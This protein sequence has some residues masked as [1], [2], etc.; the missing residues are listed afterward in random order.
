MGHI[1]KF[2]SEETDSEDEEGT[3]RLLDIGKII[4]AK[5][6]K[7][8]EQRMYE[9]I[10][11][12]QREER[13]DEK[14]RVMVG[15]DPDEEELWDQLYRTAEKED[16]GKRDKIAEILG[17]ARPVQKK[18]MRAQPKAMAAKDKEWG[19]LWSQKVWDETVVKGWSQV[20]QEARI[21]NRSIHLGKLFGICVE[22]GSELPIDD[23]GRKYKYRVVFQGNRVVDQYWEKAL[24][25]DL[26]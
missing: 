24:F 22:K 10:G 23:E 2:I 16:H 21:Q 9:N 14:I 20:A 26:G 6:K 5:E 8:R 13:R 17:V 3:A 12:A 1:L 4:R 25:Q 7:E 18:E 11:K 15:K 19:K